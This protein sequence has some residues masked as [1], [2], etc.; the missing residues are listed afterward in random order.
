MA[1]LVRLCNLCTELPSA[2]RRRQSYRKHSPLTFA[3]HPG[4]SPA[5]Q[6]VKWYPDCTV[7]LC[8][9]FVQ[10]LWAG[11]CEV[12]SDASFRAQSRCATF[13]SIKLAAASY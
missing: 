3:Y 5:K 9:P 10:Y 2:P 8:T 4:R 7:P 6:G 12:T 13:D 1:R 11:L